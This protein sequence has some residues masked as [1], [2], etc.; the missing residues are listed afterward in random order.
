MTIGEVIPWGQKSKD[1]LYKVEKHQ[2]NTREKSK[3]MLKRKSEYQLMD[4]FKE[5]E[6]SGRIKLARFERATR[7]LF[8]KCGVQLGHK[9]ELLF[10][11]ILTAYLLN[12]FGD[13][14]VSNISYLKTKYKLQELFDAVA[15][16]FPRREGKTVGTA[17]FAAIIVVSQPYGNIICY[18]IGAR[19]SEGWL[20]Q[21]IQYLDYFRE[22]DEFGWTLD[23]KDGKE[24]ISIKSKATGTTN[25]IYSY[26]CG[27]GDGKIGIG[28]IERGRPILSCRR[29]RCVYIVYS[30]V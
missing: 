18:N 28:I 24:M 2:E 27:L 25:T 16:L 4:S 22:S 14:L 3:N 19:Q 20:H 21:T 23:D 10:E 13:D 30:I 7:Y 29:R 5:L 12:M 8:D 17:I 1:L 6:C 15:I 11:A 26:P 9:Q